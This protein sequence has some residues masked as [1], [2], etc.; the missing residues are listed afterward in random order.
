MQRF[1][2]GMTV[3][4]TLVFWN[5]ENVRSQPTVVGAN[6]SEVLIQ[7]FATLD[8]GLVEAKRTGK[9][10]LF[11]SAAPHCAGVSGMW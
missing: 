1:L 10:I 7:W 8:R 3:I 2:L 5:G 6:K 9:P 4:T 11:V